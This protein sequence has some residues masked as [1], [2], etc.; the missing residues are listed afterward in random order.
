ML[1]LDRFHEL[2]IS[3]MRRHNAAQTKAADTGP[4]ET[5]GVIKVEEGL[6]TRKD[7]GELMPGARMF[8]Q[9]SENGEKF[10]MPLFLKVEWVDSDCGGF[11]KWVN[12]APTRAGRDEGGISKGV[13]NGMMNG[14][15]NGMANGNGK[16]IRKGKTREPSNDFEMVS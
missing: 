11:F 4:N 14:M 3:R 8:Q 9:V 13:L 1:S 6:P 16:V 5:N 12:K 10:S 2:E 7:V 15:A